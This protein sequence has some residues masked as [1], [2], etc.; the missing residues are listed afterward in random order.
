MSLHFYLDL[1]PVVPCP[2]ILNYNCWPPDAAAVCVV[3]KRK[4]WASAAT[5]LRRSGFFPW[6]SFDTFFH[7]L[8]AHRGNYHLAN[9]CIRLAV[10][11][12]ESRPSEEF[13]SLTF[14]QLK[15][16]FVLCGL[17]ETALFR[18]HISRSRLITQQQEHLVIHWTEKCTNPSLYTSLACSVWDRKCV[19][20]RATVWDWG[21][22]GMPARWSPKVTEVPLGASA[23]PFPPGPFIAHISVLSVRLGRTYND[24]NQYPVFP[25][26]LTNYDSE[27]LDLTVPGNFRDL[28]KV[29]PDRAPQ[30]DTV[31]VVGGGSS[32]G[33]VWEGECCGN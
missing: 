20:L 30:H 24:L 15:D 21:P 14:L 6:I 4:R 3:F 9:Q 7:L 31:V 8:P 33:G 27:E 29:P 11:F 13:L 28:S 19:W 5:W 12:K 18:P 23:P 2:P 10:T 16:M 32:S 17:K 26:V 25:W 22:V 1:S